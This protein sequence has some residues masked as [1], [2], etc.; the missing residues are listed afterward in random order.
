[1]FIRELKNCSGSVSIHIISKARSR[2]K[3]VKSMGSVTTRQEIERLVQMAKQEIDRLI[4]P[5]SLFS[6]DDDNLVEKV[7][8]SHSYFI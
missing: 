2:H 5:Q 3:V 8:S 4:K 1:M 7:I 6:S